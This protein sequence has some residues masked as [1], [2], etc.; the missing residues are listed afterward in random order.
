MEIVMK[1]NGQ[2]LLVVEGFSSSDK[3]NYELTVER[4]GEG[5]GGFCGEG[6]GVWWCGLG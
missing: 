5:W 2:Y 3:G 4:A 1:K 6:G